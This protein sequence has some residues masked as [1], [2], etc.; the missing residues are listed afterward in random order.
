MVDGPAGLGA[1]LEVTAANGIAMKHDTIQ[2]VLGKGNFTLAVSEGSFAGA[3]ASFDG[4]F[5]LEGGKIAEL[6]KLCPAGQAG[7]TTRQVRLLTTGAPWRPIR[8]RQNEGYGQAANDDA[9]EWPAG[10]RTALRNA[11]GFVPVIRVKNLLKYPASR[12]PRL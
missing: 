6:S 11:P 8:Y 1:A 3:P 4:R 9:S 10:R 5:R 2:R 7:R 12:N